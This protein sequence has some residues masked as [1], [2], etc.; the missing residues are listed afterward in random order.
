MSKLFIQMNEVR[1]RASAPVQGAPIRLHQRS[2]NPVIPTR[3]SRDS[4][5]RGNHHVKDNC[6]GATCRFR[7]RRA[8]DGRRRIACTGDQGRAGQAQRA[9]CQ[10]QNGAASPQAFTSSSRPQADRCAQEPSVLEGYDQACD[11]CHQARLKRIREGSLHPHCPAL[12]FADIG[13]GPRVIASPMAPGRCRILSDSAGAD[14]KCGFPLINE[15]A[16]TRRGVKLLKM[17]TDCIC[18]HQQSAPRW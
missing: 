4:S 10:C 9:E 18:G 17:K 13:P 2:T 12:S 3:S 14:G 5:G 15:R 11:A 8:C 1:R 6:R 7:P 16:R